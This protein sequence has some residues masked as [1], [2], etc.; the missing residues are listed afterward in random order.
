MLRILVHKQGH[1]HTTVQMVLGSS[2]SLFRTQV[3]CVLP[4]RD[5]KEEATATV[6]WTGAAAGEDS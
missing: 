5:L 4:R 1:P 6:S 2:S 3:K